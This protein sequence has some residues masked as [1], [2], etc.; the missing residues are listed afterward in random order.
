MHES[1]SYKIWPGERMPELADAEQAYRQP[2]DSTVSAFSQA[3]ASEVADK[4]MM[5]YLDPNGS[6]C[7][8]S[9]ERSPQFVCSS[10]FCD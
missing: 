7:L 2:D 4:S 3:L 1:I 6:N 10:C 8:Q 5:E 9:V